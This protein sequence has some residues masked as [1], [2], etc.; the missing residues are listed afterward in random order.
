MQ[1]ALELAVSVFSIATGCLSAVCLAHQVTVG[2]SLTLVSS[3]I[4]ALIQVFRALS[5]SRVSAVV[6]LIGGMFYLASGLVFILLD[7]VAN[8]FQT[9]LTFPLV[10]VFAVNIVTW[11]IL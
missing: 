3:F 6:S 7:L 2:T 10:V 5:T 1:L 11:G 4:M 9:T 8:K